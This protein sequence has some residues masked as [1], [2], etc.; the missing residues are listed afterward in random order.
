MLDEDRDESPPWRTFRIK[1]SELKKFFT[2]MKMEITSSASAKWMM[3]GDP[4]RGAIE[5]LAEFSR[6]L[7]TVWTM[8]R[9]GRCCRL[10]DPV[11]DKKKQNLLR[12]LCRSPSLS[13]SSLPSTW[14]SSSSSSS[15]SDVSPISDNR[16]TVPTS[17]TASSSSSSLKENV[18][19]GTPSAYYWGTLL[20]WNRD[21]E[22]E[23]EEEEDEDEWKPTQAEELG[24][25]EEEEEEKHKKR[26]KQVQKASNKEAMKGQGESGRKK[27]LNFG[28]TED[29]SVEMVSKRRKREKEVEHDYDEEEGYFYS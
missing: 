20:N 27:K 28:S 14:S 22:E 9:S 29:R 26:K 12:E 3:I 13:S 15:S 17:A 11:E 4:E 2:D 23:G 24:E 25:E 6:D 5:E 10:Y 16:Q 19:G 18:L 1:K 21:E 8:L 7:P